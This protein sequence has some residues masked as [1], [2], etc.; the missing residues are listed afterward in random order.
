MPLRK[1]LLQD[2]R[3]YLILDR[4]V[5]DYSKLFEIAKIAVRAGVDMIQLRDK[6]GTARDI[7]E[8]SKKILKLTEGRVLYIINDRV[9]V[10]IAAQASGVHLGQDDIPVEVARRMM[11]QK[12]MIGVSCQTFEHAKRAE[13]EGADYIGLGS[14][15]KTFTK[16]NRHPMNLDLLKKVIQRIKIPVFAIGGIT[17]DNV[18]GLQKIG[19]GRIAV[20]RAI[21]ESKNVKRAVVDFKEVFS[22]G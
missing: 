19:V 1:K 12:V 15:F 18:I 2:S 5:S 7:L 21:C 16:A 13:S 17:R 22:R 4:Q 11:G 6:L 20:C 10:A 14:V 9:D 8:F 3:V